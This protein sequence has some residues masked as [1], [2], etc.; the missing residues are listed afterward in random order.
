MK[1]TFLILFLALCFISP[2][3]RVS[4]GASYGYYMDLF[5]KDLKDDAVNNLIFYLESAHLSYLESPE[6]IDALDLIPSF[7]I[8][9]GISKGFVNSGVLSL[10][11]GEHST[12]YF[13]FSVVFRI[14][15]N[16]Q[17]VNYYLSQLNA[18]QEGV[19][20][21]IILLN[22]DSFD[23]QEATKEELVKFAKKPLKAMTKDVLKREEEAEKSSQIPTKI[24]D[25]NRNV[26]KVSSKPFPAKATVTDKILNTI[27]ED[28]EH[29]VSSFMSTYIKKTKVQFNDTSTEK[30]VVKI[31]FKPIIRM[32]NILWN[33]QPNTEI[34]VEVFKDI[35]LE[36][37]DIRR[38]VIITEGIVS[39][40]RLTPNRIH[41]KGL[42][43]GSSLVHIW[44]SRGRWTF[45]INIVLPTIHALDES[46][47][48]FKKDGIE[49]SKSFQ[50]VQSTNWSSFY[51]GDS[52]NSL[53]RQ[54]LIFRNWFGIYGE[55]PYGDLDASV[56]YNKFSGSTERTQQ[57]IGLK[58]GKIW[59]FRNFSIRLGDMSKRFSDLTLPGKF[60]RG[61]LWDAYT[62]DRRIYYTYFRGKEK[63]YSVR[64]TGGKGLQ[65]SVIEGVRVVLNPDNKQSNYAVN[66]VRVRDQ[67]N[68]PEIKKRVFSLET[69]QKV[70]DWT[71]YSEIGTDE[72]TV[73]L[74]LR[75]HLKRK[76]DAINVSF[77]KISKGYR[78]VVGRPGKS[79]E[80]GILTR[81]ERHEK[82]WSMNADLDVY[83]DYEEN[84]LSG[85]HKSNSINFDF[86]TSTNI[87][88]D[89]ET[90]LLS[91]L[92]FIHTPQ[93][94]SPVT[95]FRLYNTLTRKFRIWHEKYLLA[96]VK[97]S[98][99]RNRFKR[100]SK[101]NFDRNA[102]QLGIRL[103]IWKRINYFLSYEQSFVNRVSVNKTSTPSVM[104]TGL[105][106]SKALN[107]KTSFNGN[108]TYTDEEDTEDDFSFLSGTDDLRSSVGIVY[109][110]TRN[111]QMFLNG[112][113]RT[114]WR[115]AS[116]EKS[117]N[118]VDVRMGVKSTWDTF[119]RW[120]PRGYVRGLVYIDS[121]D[122][123]QYDKG[124]K[125]VENVMIDV[126]TQKVITNQF[127][128]YY[129]KIK[130]KKVV[131]NINVESLP[132]GYFLTTE[133]RK[134]IVIEAHRTSYV[135][136]GVK[137]QTLIKGFAFVDEN[138]NDV[139]DPNETPVSYIRV[140]LD[141]NMKQMTDIRGRYNFGDLTAGRYTIKVDL[142]TI[143]LKY[144]PKKKLSNSI[145]VREGASFQHHIPLKRK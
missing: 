45:N 89:K 75:A 123:G 90:R 31:D 79:G 81:Y 143:P 30:D 21:D 46:K 133:K 114:V 6:P 62:D 60:M 73:S 28:N 48:S 71:V 98:Y 94:L 118:E 74:N 50:F 25:T 100:I 69:N 36:G 19:I 67:K 15:P 5:Y 1:K 59:K 14:D 135:S 110:P 104:R 72:D 11:R 131:A 40:D 140:S 97:H 87:T 41:I 86:R 4:Q 76:K 33:K 91:A 99:Q 137:S 101:A 65:R 84:I 26:H 8:Y 24:I 12:A 130:A 58:N 134:D 70:R 37:N 95:N 54:S 92:Y 29:R 145:F 106:Y 2:F 113:F 47:E 49:Y 111:I 18:L 108:I 52:V 141:D 102:I 78:T 119:L 53:K 66:F 132:K 34:S 83:R 63:A 22:E 35:V 122:N 55:T 115:E 56:L 51:L 96:S 10:L 42:K 9:K 39:L 125:G 13:Y 144:L 126:G 61:V 77:R 23:L 93:L 107:S 120:N 17:K 127:G 116:D 103:P 138:D 109:S 16:N 68:N 27:Y 142:S 38:F 124:E 128:W 32:D 85:S 7:Q 112:S 64:S 136:F 3:S 105:S 80:V 57:T 20:E 44:D 82:L 88:I 43:K 121:N 117:F 129:A 139:F